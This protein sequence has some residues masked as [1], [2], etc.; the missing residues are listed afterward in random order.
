MVGVPSPLI[1]WEGTAYSG[2]SLISPNLSSGRDGSAVKRL[3]SFSDILLN[4]DTVNPPVLPARLNG[5]D[6]LGVLDCLAS[7][8]RTQWLQR[9]HENCLLQSL[10]PAQDDRCIAC[11]AVE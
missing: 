6:P 7:S 8:V 5:L 4:A 1:L 11:P 2:F 10:E 3:S 9:G